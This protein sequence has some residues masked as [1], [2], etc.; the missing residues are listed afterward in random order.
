MYDQPGVEGIRMTSAGQCTLSGAALE[1]VSTLDEVIVEYAKTL[2]ASELTFPPLMA[3]LDLEPVDYLGSFP[4]LATFAVALDDAEANL[5]TF[6]SNDVIDTGGTVAL[7][8]LQPVTHVL[9]P[10]ACYNLYIHHRG[11]D[12]EQTTYFTTKCNCFRRE[13]DYTPLER[14]WSFTMREL[15]CVGN[16]TTAVEFLARVKEFAFSLVEHLG[17]TTSWIKA[18]DPFFQ[19]TKNPK[20]IMQVVD[21]TKDELVFDERLAIGSANLHHQHF[22]SSY[23]IRC[24]DEIATTACF[25]FGL[26]RWLAALRDTHGPDPVNWP[27]P[28]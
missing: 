20:Y 2:N 25:A 16:A 17:L 12:F 22:G 3:A 21:P 19:P 13:N 24:G 10:A 6:T 8:E 5:A 28:A 7:T 26:E 23:E 27:K 4:H 18:T 11:A 15:V 14:Q 9:T 1:Y